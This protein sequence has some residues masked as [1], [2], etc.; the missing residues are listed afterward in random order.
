[1]PKYYKVKPEFDGRVIKYLVPD[2]RK[3]TGYRQEE[4]ELIGYELLSPKKYAQIVR[5]KPYIV[6]AF[7]EVQVNIYTVYRSF[8]ALFQFG[9][10]D[11]ICGEFWTKRKKLQVQFT[12]LYFKVRKECPSST[13]LSWFSIEMLEFAIKYYTTLMLYKEETT[14]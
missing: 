9:D 1:M 4:I 13:L 3:R 8:G 2:G 6:D 5:Y 7:D 11:K 12:L 14:K 10:S